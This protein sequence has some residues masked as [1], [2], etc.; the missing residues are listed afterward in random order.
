MAETIAVRPV[1]TTP[2]VAR[3]RT[4]P[5]AIPRVPFQVL[6][7]IGVSGG[8]YAVSLAAVA[9]WQSTSERDLAAARAPVADAVAGLAA[10]N[11][12]LA[13]RLAGLGTLD[14][15]AADAQ[16][17]VTNQFGLV[18]RQ[19]DHLSSA[20]AAVDGMARGLPTRV[21]LPPAVHSVRIGTSPTA[22]AATG[23]SAV[24]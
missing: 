3:R 24:P 7:M 11:D 21:A 10:T 22:H 17:S 19:L 14:T 6:A 5:R 23:G 12:R 1:A 13:A 9:A 2:I 16:T 15:A 20:V 8:C 18:E 4:A